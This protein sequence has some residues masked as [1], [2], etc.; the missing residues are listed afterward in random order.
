MLPCAVALRTCTV[1]FRGE[2]GVSHQIEV[3]AE[4]LFEA[5]AQALAIFRSSDW[6]EAIGPSTEL[7][8]AVRNPETKHR[9]TLDQIRRW[10]EGVAA[11]PNDVLERHRVKTLIG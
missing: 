9:V 2:R 4:S 10:C 11:S 7:L 8:V 1:S 3:S 6:A 5:A